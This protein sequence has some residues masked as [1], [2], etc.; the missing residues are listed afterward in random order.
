MD[1][2]R[3]AINRD[4]PVIGME[5]DAVRYIPLAGRQREFRR[6]A[7]SEEVGQVNPIVCRPRLL[8]EDN[9]LVALVTARGSQAFAELVTGHPIADND[10]HFTCTTGCLSENKRGR[11]SLHVHGTLTSPRNLPPRNAQHP[12]S[13][14][15]EF[16]KR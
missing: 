14:L 3:F 6:I 4:D 15:R 2:S 11:R 8:S 1:G 7:P 5:L 16:H 13:S 9:N 10:Q 12:S